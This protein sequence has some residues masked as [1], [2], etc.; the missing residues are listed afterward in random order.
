[1]PPGGT[2]RLQRQPQSLRTAAGGKRQLSAQF[3]PA[4]RLSGAS[5]GV[6]PPLS[7]GSDRHSGGVPSSRQRLQRT[8]DV[9]ARA[10]RGEAGA[11]RHAGIS[12]IRTGLPP[13]GAG[14]R[15]R[16]AP[17]RRRIHTLYGEAGAIHPPRR[18]GDRRQ[19]RQSDRNGGEGG[20]TGGAGRAAPRC[21]VPD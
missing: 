21:D 18:S 2:A 9:P 13:G 16:S 8:S 14:D 3:R 4:R 5:R 1:M 10:H 6:A 12:R 7:G 11:D 15:I 17:A 20:G 19:P